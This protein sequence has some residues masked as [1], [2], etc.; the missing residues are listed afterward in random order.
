LRDPGLTFKIADTAAEIEAI[1]R[2]NHRT[3]AEEIPQH[4]PDPR[5]RLVDRFHA[6]NTYAICLDGPALVGMVAGRCARPFSL[7]G[8]LRRLDTHLPAGRTPVEVRLLAIEPRYRRTAVASR[9]LALLAEHFAARGCDLAVIS[10]TTRA[11]GLY[12]RLGFVPFGPLVGAEGA[13]FQPMY[14]TLEDASRTW[15]AGSLGAPTGGSGR[16]GGAPP[17][18]FLPGPVAIAPEVTAAFA[19]PAAYHRSAEFVATVRGVRARLARLTN[20]ADVQ[21]LLGSGTLANDVVAVQLAGLDRPGLVLANGEFGE[22]LV[23][24]GRRIGLEFA[25]LA[26]EWGRPLAAAEVAAAVHR[27]PAGGWVWAVHCETST[28]TLTDVARLSELC[29]TA[30]VRLCLDCISSVGALPLDLSGVYLASGASGKA[31]GSYP[32]LSLVFHAEP[33]MP[34]AGRVPR[35]LDLRAYALADGVAFTQS[36]NLVAAL[37]TALTAVDWP[38]RYVRLAEGAAWLHAALRRRGFVVVAGAADAA[39]AVLT[40]ALPR[41]RPADRVAERMAAEGYLLAY[42]SGYLRCRNWLQ[43][44]LMGRW[45]WPSL[46]ALPPALERA[47]RATTADSRSAGERT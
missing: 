30:G 34:A 31:L 3:F 40:V 26:G 21:L 2:L 14:L 27:L 45:T 25:V 22:R 7:D 1:H 47:A 35:Y 46:R 16:I 42:Q 39:P 23:D 28:G 4:R 9:L 24:H 12:R 37:D 17:A 20:A 8:K 29:A 33:P 19:R 18:N 38:V 11:L 13:W 36:S 15:L 5:G 10:G 32:G 6:E 44:G 41:D 43:V